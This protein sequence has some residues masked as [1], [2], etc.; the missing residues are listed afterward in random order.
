[1]R[2]ERSSKEIEYCK[3]VV[4]PLLQATRRLQRVR[5]RHGNT[6]FGKDFTFSYLNPLS[7]CINCGVQVKYGDISGKSKRL[8]TDLTNQ[9]PV[10]FSVPYKDAPL[11]SGNYINELYI[12]C[13]GKYTNHAITVIESQLSPQKYNAQFWDGEY[14][15][16]LREKLLMA[17][18]EEVRDA[19]Q[20]L[21]SLLIE[22]D[23][24]IGIATE[25]VRTTD[26]FIEKKKHSL[27]NYRLNCLERIL[28][29]N[30]DDKWII[31]EAIIEWNNLTID[32]NLLSD[33][34]VHGGA[35][36]KK[37]LKEHTGRN[38]NNL[39]D[40]KNYIVQYLQK[41]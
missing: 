24:N 39:I 10:A 17:S 35:E 7:V 31:D 34:R 37:Q 22:I 33:I 32:N 30:I 36:K 8:I 27:L 12:I 1:M 11:E 18:R 23:H 40:F 15:S 3:S 16:Y 2:K 14:V 19:Q 26:N 4:Y 21:N 25:I 13:S 41:I 20:A 5:Y 29:M 28:G 6:E 38:I 9:I